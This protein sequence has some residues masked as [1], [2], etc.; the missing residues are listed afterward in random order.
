MSHVI[1]HRVGLLWTG[2]AES[3]SLSQQSLIFLCLCIKGFTHN[4]ASV[5]ADLQNKRFIKNN[6]AAIRRKDVYLK[7]LFPTELNL[8]DSR[9]TGTLH[10]SE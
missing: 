3:C 1:P 7:L 6:V 10:E 2:E 4:E 9:V 5:A 8:H